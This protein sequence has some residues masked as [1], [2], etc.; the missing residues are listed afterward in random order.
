MPKNKDFLKKLQEEARLQ[1]K[2]EQEKLLPKQLDGVASL[3]A[4]HPWQVI[5][6]L[7]LL[8]AA[9]FSFF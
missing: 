3:I 2:L 9:L 7:A 4:T 1:A 5:S 8:T 6:I